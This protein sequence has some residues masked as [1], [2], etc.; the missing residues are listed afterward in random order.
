VGYTGEKILEG[1]ISGTLPIYWGNPRINEDF[2]NDSFINLY[3]F[4]NEDD[5]IEKII[6]IDRN[7]TLYM[8]YFEQ[9]IVKKDSCFNVNYML[10]CMEKITENL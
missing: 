6:E 5:V 10:S 4:D 9:P 2:N 7:D 8:K 1:F 3:D